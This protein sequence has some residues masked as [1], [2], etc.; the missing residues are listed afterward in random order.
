LRILVTA[1]YVSGN[2]HE[3]GSS[4]FYKCVID[5]L[6]AMG[7]EVIATTEPKRYANEKF[8]IIICSH[9]LAEIKD[10]PARKIFVAQ[11]II[12]DEFMTPGADQYISISEEVREDNITRGFDSKVIGQPIVIGE[13]QR[14]GRELKN[15]LIIRREPVAADPFAFLKEKYDVRVSDLRIPIEEQIAWADLCIT[16]GRGAL[17]AMAQGKPVLVADNR[18]Y[19]GAYG[20]GY[21][22]R[23]S[24]FEVAKNNF[25]GR[26]YKYTLTRE[27]IEKELAKYNADDSDFLYDWVRETHEAGMIVRRYLEP[28]PAIKIAFGALVSDICRLDMVLRQSAIEG[29]IH[30]VKLP[31]SAT[32]G[33]NTLLGIMEGE[34]AD[35]AVLTHQ[36]MYYRQGW[37]DQVREQLLKLP[38]SWIVAGV[39]GKD[40]DGEMKGMF[41]DMRMPLK[42]AYGPLPCEASCF[43][44]CCI[45]VNLKKG[46]RFDETLEGFDLYG[47]MAVLQAQEMGGTAWVIDAYCEHYCMR[48]FTWV[49]DKV[50]GER[51]IWL[52]R[53]FPKAKRIDTTVLG[54]PREESRPRY[55]QAAA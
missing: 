27:W 17:E 41:Q 37:L 20:D 23:Y 48:P 21:L 36:D 22:N 29:K 32:K 31:T 19:I 42:F 30:T 8:D 10:N 24:L 45:L 16:L 49:P 2:S 14:P 53:R 9:V 39:I 4:R 47:T 26:R 50:F 43:D 44:E 6:R 5:A 3:G 33:L 28:A 11:G 51:F 55:D 54:L 46:F 12:G 18:S 15:I 40:M 35:V 1:K 52:H 7:H 34:G 25:S 38:D 13:Q